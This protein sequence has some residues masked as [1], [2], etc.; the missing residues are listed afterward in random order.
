MKLR[1]IFL[2]A[3]V[4]LAL[5]ACSLADDITPPPGYQSPVPQPTAGPVFPAS[6]PDVAAGA[7]IFAEKC[8]PCHGPSGMGDGPQASKLPKKPTALGDPTVAHAAIPANWYNVVTQGRIENYMPP[9]T[10]LNDQQ[11]WDVVAYALS[12]S[13]SA[14][15]GKTVYETNCAD[16]HG[17]DGKKSTKSDFTDQ[18]RMAKLSLN[19]LVGF[20]N[21]GIDKMPAYQGKLSETERYAAA[22]YLR[23]FSLVPAIAATQPAPSTSSGQAATE[24]ASGTAIATG[25]TSS[26]AG[27]PSATGTISGK[28]TNQSGSALPA[29]LK[30]VLH[31]FSHDP[32]SNAF[33]E[34]DSLNTTVD[35]S[36]NYAFAN[37]AIPTNYAYFVSVDH[38]GT[39]YSSQPVVPAAGVTTYDLPLDIYDTTNDLS[40]LVADQVHIILDY[41]KPDVI[42]VVE[43]YS[44]TNPSTKTVIAASKG[45]PLINVT[46]PKGYKNLQFQDGA[47]GDRFVQTGEGFG[48]TSAIPPSAAPASSAVNPSATPAA[49]TA[50]QIIFAYDLPYSTNFDFVQPF[51]LNVTETQFLVSEGVK[52]QAPGIMDGDIADMGNDGGKYQR[53]KVG[54][55]KSGQT[56][57]V[58]VSGEP[59]K[60]SQ[61]I[62]GNDTSRN[63]IIGIGTLGLVLMLAGGW[64]FLRDR[65]RIPEK[66]F[67][68]QA[69]SL[70]REEI[71]DAIIALDD[72]H[73]AGN[74]AHDAY[75][76]RRAELKEKFQEV[77]E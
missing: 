30:V 67:A 41:S 26:T 3:G 50:F 59:I 19:D 74:I 11:R 64:L 68:P 63:L 34:L 7:V 69:N 65:K 44:I 17:V 6:P 5:S 77:D 9:F 31:V 66:R 1:S 47:I 49:N 71:L 60:N 8:T 55:F 13:S 4:L 24:S 32:V 57:T 58:T 2:L 61:P 72:Q 75:Q 33:S 62:A 21:K 42:Q 25:T 16:C 14:G 73:N 54:S 38:G 22:A 40:V 52:A 46:L 76:Q 48:D 15:Q 29:D 28:I 35:A 70:T 27:T 18:A 37:V 56:M 53:Y 23:S 43:F 12:L 51:S 20:I 36:G 39:T 45:A 10:S